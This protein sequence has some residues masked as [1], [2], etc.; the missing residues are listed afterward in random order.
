MEIKVVVTM[1]AHVDDG[2]EF[3]DEQLS[4]AAVE[5]VDSAL[6]RAQDWGFEHYLQNDI[7]FGYKVELNQG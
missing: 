2:K 7:S 4:R 1:Y 3:T 5:A 6:Y